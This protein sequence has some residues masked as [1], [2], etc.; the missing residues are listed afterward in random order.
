MLTTAEQQTLDALIGTRQPGYSLPGSFYR[1]ALV[2]RADLETIWQQEWLFVGHSCEVAQPG[3]FL[4]WQVGND[5]LLITRDDQGELH[6]L[7]NVCRHRGT[8]LCEAPSGQ[9][10]RFV[11]PYH[12]WTYAADGTLVSCRGMHEVDRSALG[13]RRA[14]IREVAGLMFVSLAA[15]PP[16]FE[17]AAACLQPLLAP[18]GL[19]RA[20]VARQID[21]DVAANWKLVWE[22]N[23]ECY[24]CNVNHPQYVRANFDHYNRDD[25]TAAIR[26]KID[27]AVCHH[28]QQVADAGIA[29]THRESGMTVFPD[30]DAGLW[31]SANRTPL[32]EGYVS[33]SLD[34]RQ[35]APL[36]GDYTSAAVGTLRMRTVPN[37][38][39]HSS[40]DHSVST[41]LLATGPQSTQIRVTWLVDQAAVEG[42][43]YQLDDLLPFWQRTSEQDWELCERA[44]RGIAS[45][46]YRPGPYSDYKEYNVDRFVR[47]Y[48]R[49]LAAGVN[50][51]TT[52]GEP[53]D[54]PA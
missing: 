6:A 2:Y 24:H 13:L 40:C 7:F 10:R 11:C 22:N 41:R 4:T 45:A 26:R 39:N 31:Y 17:A 14:H 43:D 52:A 53:T 12:Q 37:F 23:R 38:W 30:P 29:I 32:V 35:V 8:L 1:D 21:Y 18:Q 50:Q 44:Q 28:Q 20:R 33:E 15:Q 34:G 49:R 51:P 25:T 54:A 46:G 9:R 42:R 19:E 3:D 47:W 48:L 16:P 27:A 5:P 36:M